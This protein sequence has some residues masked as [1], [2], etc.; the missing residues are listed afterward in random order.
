MTTRAPKEDRSVAIVFAGTPDGDNVHSG[1]RTSGDL[2]F[3]AAAA[4]NAGVGALI[5]I[6]REKNL[7]DDKLARLRYDNSGEAGIPVLVITRDVAEKIL[8]ARSPLGDYGAAAEVGSLLQTS[9]E[10]RNTAK[11]RQLQSPKS[12]CFGSHSE[13]S[14][15]VD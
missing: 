12:N 4:R 11:A 10:N 3:K 8:A 7:R 1:V 2:R 15:A 9:P 6:S 13:H 5:V 14:V